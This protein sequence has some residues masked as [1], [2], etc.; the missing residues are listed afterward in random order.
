MRI[1]L[2]LLCLLYL[3]TGCDRVGTPTEQLLLHPHE[4]EEPRTHP[5]HNPVPFA[6]QQNI[7]ESEIL[8][9]RDLLS[10]E[11][12]DREEIDRII[13]AI[14]TRRE[15]AENYVHY[16]DVDGMA[17]VG[18]KGTWMNDMA[19]IMLTMTS[20]RPAIRKQ[21]RYDTGFYFVLFHPRYFTMP[22]LPEWRSIKELYYPGNTLFIIP[23]GM[24]AFDDKHNI[25]LAPSAVWYNE[26]QAWGFE[27]SWKVAIHEF[28]H[29]IDHA[30][31]KIDPSFETKLNQAYE[32]AKE[33]ELWTYHF[34]AV[35]DSAR[36]NPRE[37]WALGIEAWFFGRVETSFGHLGNTKSPPLNKA[38][39]PELDPLLYKLLDEWLPY[40][41]LEL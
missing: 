19:N 39:L 41:D 33:K 13:E 24:C 9:I 12:D 32:N 4:A 6:I 2:S 37:Y 34:H 23:A 15:Q 25:C 38:T 30:V 29:A 10:L 28:G 22:E 17:L 35:P 7:W 20:K 14:R 5:V 16:V 18:T 11:I 31:R 21:L 1:L 36:D 8:L 3:L 27:N 40:A 26:F